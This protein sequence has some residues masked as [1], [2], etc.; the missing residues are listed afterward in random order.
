[1]GIYSRYIDMNICN[2]YEHLFILF[3][4]FLE[5]LPERLKMQKHQKI[6]I[7]RIKITFFLIFC[8]VYR[9]VLENFHY[10]Y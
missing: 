1:M 10:I 4:R 3:V 8:G 6:K 7:R 5:K 9:A 2:R